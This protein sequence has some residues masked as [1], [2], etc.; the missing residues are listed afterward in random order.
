MIWPNSWTHGGFR[1]AGMTENWKPVV[2]HERRFEVSDQ[3]SVRAVF[4]RGPEE[5]VQGHSDK[6]RRV[7]L[8]GK[9]YSVHRLV[10]EAFLPNPSG[11]PVVRHLDD[12]G[13]NNSLENLAWG[14]YSDNTQDMLRLG[15]HAKQKL[16][17]CP[18]GHSYS[19][20]NLIV[21]SNGDRYC[22]KCIAASWAKPVVC[23]LCSL[24]LTRGGLPR[25]R[26]SPSCTSG[27][28]R[29]NQVAKQGGTC[30]KGHVRTGENT[31]WRINSKGQKI[32]D[33]LDCEKARSC[34]R[35]R[36]RG[37]CPSCGKEM[38]MKSI[39]DHLTQSCKAGVKAPG[40]H[41]E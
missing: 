40:G 8:D 13:T 15:N 3:G 27:D 14:T 17:H 21:R 1:W 31:R 24:E 10:A 29:R 35:K 30:P 6:Y 32:R 38:L 28:A 37:A 25:H 11:L 33:C 2:G 34:G 9:A 22:R 23:D 41:D 5:L 19:G 16:T 18:E 26:G 4:D 39:K 20:E 36:P 12:V 7:S